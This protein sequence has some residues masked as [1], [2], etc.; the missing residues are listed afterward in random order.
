MVE[1]RYPVSSLVYDYLRGI[2]G[3][4]ISVVIMQSIGP[5]PRSS[6]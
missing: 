6:G 4:G 1:L 3:L 5:T 2:L